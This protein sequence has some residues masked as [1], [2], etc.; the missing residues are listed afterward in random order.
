LGNLGN[1]MTLGFGVGILSALLAALF[2]VLNKK[3]VNT[4]PPPPLLMTC[5]ELSTAVLVCSIA[6]I[7]LYGQGHDLRFQP[8]GM[9]WLWLLVLAYACTLLP[10]TLSIVA[11]RHISAFGTN[12]TINL[13]PVYGV[14]L[15]ILFFREDKDLN[16]N[17]YYGVLIIL[18]AVFSHPL[19]KHY[20]EGKAELRP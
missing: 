15:A 16:A 17:F 18:V 4:S 11:M 19:L 10:F 20:F 6:L 14:L 2:S 7:L 3:I 9:D 13:E 5:V 8:L 1:D 12:L